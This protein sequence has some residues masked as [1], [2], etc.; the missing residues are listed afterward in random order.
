MERNPATLPRPM[1]YTGE[2]MVP[3]AAGTTTFWEHISRYHFALPFVRGRRVLDIACGEGYGTKALARAGAASVVGVDISPEACR[4][5]AS[6]YGIDAREGCAT[7]IPLPSQSVDVIVSFETVEHVHSPDD[8]LRECAR[9]LNP[10]GRLIMSTP[11]KL[12][13]SDCNGGQNPFHSN[14]MTEVE[15]RRLVGRYFP[16]Q[17]MYMQLFRRAP[18]WCPASVALENSPWRNWRGHWRLTERHKAMI[19]SLEIDARKDPVGA[20]LRRQSW[21]ARLFDP[22]SVWRKRN[23]G[24]CRAVYLICVAS[25][26]R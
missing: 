18:R 14:E 16:H 13:Y 1:T 6:K 12:T 25:L 8:F 15:F 7:A 26:S 21:V 23:H 22:Y 9:V 4:H 5:A 19:Q 17:E 20:I 11:D 2:R 24:S 10:G 3:E